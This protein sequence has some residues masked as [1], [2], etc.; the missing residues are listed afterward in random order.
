[1][2]LCASFALPSQAAELRIALQDA[3]TGQPLENAVVEV[4]L[5]EGL[6]GEYS[7]DADYNV[8][9]IEKEFVAEVTVITVGSR[10]S[11]PNSD[12]ILHHVYSFSPANVFE[13]PLHGSGQNINYPE[14]FEQAGV[15]EIGCNIHD[16]MLGYIYVAQ[17][18]LAVRTDA[19][20]QALISDV[21]AGNF[22]V[23]VWHPRLPG[24]SAELEQE[25]GFV[26]A[27]ASNLRMALTLDRDNRLRRAPNASRARYR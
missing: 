8:D 13:L 20:G 22:R 17:T 26:D 18:R 11:F 3:E 7:A 9:Q 19:N 25:I 16:W 27:Q 1:M 5:P 2:A 12:N 24:A 21:P 14:L 10:V 23:R 15:V 6:Q 4:F